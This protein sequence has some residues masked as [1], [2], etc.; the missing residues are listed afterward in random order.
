MK[1]VIN[2]KTFQGVEFKDGKVSVAEHAEIGGGY[3]K[4]MGTQIP[5]GMHVTEALKAARADYTVEKQP[6]I[7]V[8]PKLM[9]AMANGDQ[10][11]AGSLMDDVIGGVKA[12]MRM[13]T[14][15]TLGIVSEGYGVVQNEDVFKF[16]DFMC[17]GNGNANRTEVPV[18]ETVGVINGGQQIFASAKFPEVIKFDD[19]GNDIANMY[20]M[21][22]STHDGS[23]SVR[24]V[25]TPIRVV[26]QNTLNL[27]L[28]EC[29]GRLSFK[30][31]RFVNDRM[32]LTNK[33]NA[34]RAFRA[35]NLYSVYKKSFEE[36]IE[37][38]KKVKIENDKWI[39]KTLAEA[40]L[41]ADN[42]DLYKKNNFDL[43]CDDISTRSRNIITA[44]R[45]SIESGVGQDMGEKGTGLWLLNGVTTY[46][47]NDVSF[48]TPE[49]KFES[50]SD[51]SAYAKVQKVHDLI[52]ETA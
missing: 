31:T 44:C 3:W 7:A 26:C 25:V 1:A 5:E 50:L 45:D 12:T 39:E 36:E 6:V 49:K 17:S 22:T 2:S 10:I 8:T 52:L 46:F 30:H 18:L 43:N 14:I 20:I 16:V 35:L 34:E 33:E 28:R 41:S 4:G 51:G 21:M 15:K 19:K 27:A 29:R 38:L 32:D 48:K 9:A 47:S 13:D 42:F 24:V 40:L 23:G 11:D 37:R